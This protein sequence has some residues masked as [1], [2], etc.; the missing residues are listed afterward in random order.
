[1]HVQGACQ[2]AQAGGASALLLRQHRRPPQRACQAEQAGRAGALLL[3]QHRRPPQRIRQVVQIVDADVLVDGAD[4]GG[5]HLR[6]ADRHGVL[7]ALGVDRN[8][9]AG[10]DLRGTARSVCVRS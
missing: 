2:V 8:R 5:R 10:F 9:V 4:V 1:M 7:L 6:D 3:C